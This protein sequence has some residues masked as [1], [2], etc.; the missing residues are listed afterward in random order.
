VLISQN[1]NT[2]NQPNFKATIV[3]SKPAF[4]RALAL[5]P[6]S[7]YVGEALSFPEPK[8]LN[9]GY[10]TGALICTMGFIKPKGAKEGYLFHSVPGGNSFWNIR[11]GLVPILEGFKN[12]KTGIEGILIGADATQRA[13]MEHAENLMKLFDEYKVRYSALIGQTINSRRFT[14]MFAFAQ[15]DVYVVDCG[16]TPKMGDGLSRSFDTVNFDRADTLVV[17]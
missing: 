15:G 12:L 8:M 9:E 10:S 13:S 5:F 14:H 11:R 3:C 16:L 17:G 6:S 1:I 7:K 4:H 2:Q